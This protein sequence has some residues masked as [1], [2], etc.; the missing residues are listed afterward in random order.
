MTPSESISCI[1]V[2]ESN[3]SFVGAPIEGRQPR[4]CKA[5]TQGCSELEDKVGPINSDA[6]VLFDENM[7]E[8]VKCWK[9]KSKREDLPTRLGPCVD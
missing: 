1:Y 9:L 5:G 3:V 2:T 4:C 7:S 8:R 6:S